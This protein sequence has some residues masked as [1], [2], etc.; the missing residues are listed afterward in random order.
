M[1]RRSRLPLLVAVAVGVL[2]AL[3]KFVPAYY[4]TLK[5]AV[6]CMHKTPSASE[7][8][9]GRDILSTNV[10]PTHYDLTIT[11]DMANFVFDGQVAI[12]Y[13]PPRATRLTAHQPRR[14]GGLVGHPAQR[15]G[16]GHPLR[17]PLRRPRVRPARWA[18]NFLFRKIGTHTDFDCVREVLTLTLEKPLKAGTHA[19]LTIQYSGIINDKMAGFYRSSY[20]D[21]ATGAKTYRA[22]A[23]CC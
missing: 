16:T 18:S 23:A 4:V 1:Q 9:A 15:Q 2:T 20:T 10:R 13:A 8:T 14:Q 17:H 3:F 11:P 19:T 6:S 7:A 22:C 5:M 12:Q 21:K